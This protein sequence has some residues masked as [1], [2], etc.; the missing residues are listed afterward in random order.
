MN[1][2]Q[3]NSN[4]SSLESLDTFIQNFEFKLLQADLAEV[5]MTNK[6]LK[7]LGLNYDPFDLNLNEECAQILENLGLSIHFQNPYVA[8][9]ILLKLLDKVEERLNN[10]KH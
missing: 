4:H 7:F 6:K 5:E 10:L 9:N 2:L 3:K 8:T 1:S